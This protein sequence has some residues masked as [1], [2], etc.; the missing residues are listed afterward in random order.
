MAPVSRGRGPRS[1]RKGGKD[2]AEPGR[3]G[4]LTAGAPAAWAPAGG[5]GRPGSHSRQPGDAPL[6]LGRAGSERLR[7]APPPR[8]PAGL[9]CRSAGPS[10]SAYSLPP[11]QPACLAPPLPSA[12]LLRAR[13][14]DS[15]RRTCCSQ[16]GRHH[17]R[18]SALSA[19]RS[20]KNPKRLGTGGG[21]EPSLGYRPG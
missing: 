3:A 9:C 5:A 12:A 8:P 4:L 19:V 1:S 17:R 7:T 21:G 18:P 20:R 16:H 10:C 13:H 2:G 11:Q 14:T 6:G 15:H